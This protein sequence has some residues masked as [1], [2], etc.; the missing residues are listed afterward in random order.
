LYIKN[1]LGSVNECPAPQV[2]ARSPEKLKV[3]ISNLPGE[4]E[5]IIG[6]GDSPFLRVCTAENI[7]SLLNLWIK[8]TELN[9]ERP[10]RP[11]S[12]L[13]SR[14]SL[15][16]SQWLAIEE[17]L[18]SSATIFFLID[19][20]FEIDSNFLVRAKEVI[21]SLP[22]DWEIFN[23]DKTTEA[24]SLYNSQLRIG[25]TDFCV[26]YQLYA[27]TCMMF[28]RK[29]AKKYLWDCLFGVRSLAAGNSNIDNNIDLRV[30]NLEVVGDFNRPVMSWRTDWSPKRRLKSFQFIPEAKSPV[31]N[32]RAPST[33]RP[34]DLE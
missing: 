26:N 17:F 15:H 9:P 31:R 1:L 21:E 5:N 16:F 34:Q 3:Y 23:F 12:L 25:N 2:F 10:D 6:P 4:F 24:F 11:A 27:G 19:D 14:F 20:D 32:T 22:V 8:T 33:M 28:T 18:L 7:E 29:G 13:Y 30:A